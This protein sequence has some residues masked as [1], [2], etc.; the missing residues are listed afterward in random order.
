MS[1]VRD[2]CDVVS[3]LIAKWHT[4]AMRPK[5][6]DSYE[7]HLLFCPPCLIQNDKARLALAALSTAASQPPPADLVRQLTDQLTSRMRGR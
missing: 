1:T 3:A 2:R 6:R 7:Q 4:G 5:D